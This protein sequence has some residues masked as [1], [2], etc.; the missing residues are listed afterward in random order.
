MSLTTYTLRAK[1]DLSGHICLGAVDYMPLKP[2]PE[3]S[4][5][6]T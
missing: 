5:V 2:F 3:P 6:H 4:G 1:I